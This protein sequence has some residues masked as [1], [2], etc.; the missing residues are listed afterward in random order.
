MTEDNLLL[1]IAIGAMFTI[2]AF[3]TFL[4]VPTLETLT[5]TVIWIVFWLVI[6]WRCPE[7]RWWMKR[8]EV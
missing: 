2:I 7:T 1:F 4:A 8:D 5:A 6:L 3:C